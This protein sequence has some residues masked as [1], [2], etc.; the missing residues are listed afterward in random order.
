MSTIG[1][2]LITYEGFD[3]FLAIYTA[4]P[5]P[6]FFWDTC[7]LLEIIRFIYRK[8]NGMATLNAILDLANKANND[9]IYCVT[10][11]L[12]AI[13]WD[14]NVDRVLQE[15]K[16]DLLKTEMYHALAAATI[17]TILLGTVQSD[18]ISTFRLEEV[19]R[20]IALNIAQSSHFICYKDISDDTL[21]RVA[22]KTP[23]AK[24]KDAEIKDCAMW[25]TMLRICSDIKGTMPGGSPNKVF[26]TV[27]TKDFADKSRGNA[28]FFNELQSEASL[29]GFNCALLIDDAVNSL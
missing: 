15:I 21:T 5:K 4:T 11:E 28:V 18:P 10:S 12:A 6:I 29:M 22:A 8:N 17:N 26:Y 3:D 2:K 27:N 23:P 7:G 16:E 9:E 1:G 24:E 20:D 25:E 19:L 13:E 14:D